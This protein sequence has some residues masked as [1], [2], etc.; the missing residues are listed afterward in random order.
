MKG[1]RFSVFIIIIFLVFQILIYKVIIHS[2]EFGKD[3]ATSSGFEISK[4]ER[5]PYNIEHMLPYDSPYAIFVDKSTQRLHIYYIEDRPKIIKTFLC[6]TGQVLGDKEEAGDCKTPEGIYYFERIKERSEL[7][8]KYGVRAF[9]MNYPNS[10]DKLKGR[11]G[12]GI[13]LH[14]TNEPNRTMLPFST[15]GCIIVNNEDIMELSQYVSLNKTPII[16]EKEIKFLERELSL[17]NK[18]E[19][20]R[21]ISEWIKDWENKNID[22]YME[23][24]S[25]DFY[26]QKKNWKR[27]K[28]YKKGLF[29]KYSWIK[30]TVEGISILEKEN[31]YIVTFVQKFTS[32][33][34]TDQ[35]VKRIYIYKEPQGFKIIN[36]EWMPGEPLFARTYEK[37]GTSLDGR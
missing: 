13:W 4:N 23:N 36:E 21:F 7:H 32:D 27:W 10:F 1:K 16:V 5:L 8:E 34:F 33:Q 19:I 11:N 2:Q 35:G 25:K 37:E 3:R 15:Q 29:D 24:Y 9:V 30:V 14:S 28:N 12:S 20:E 17:R 26:S 31:N 6:S 22:E 18:K